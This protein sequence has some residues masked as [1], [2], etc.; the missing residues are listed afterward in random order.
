[1]I[2]SDQQ[3]TGQKR[4]NVTHQVCGAPRHLHGMVGLSVF[5]KFRDQASDF[6]TKC[7]GHA[8]ESLFPR[9]ATGADTSPCFLSRGFARLLTLLLFCLFFLFFYFLFLTLVLILLAFVSH[10]VPPFF[11]VPHLLAAMTILRREFCLLHVRNLFDDPLSFGSR[12]IIPIHPQ[13]ELGTQSRCI[14]MWYSL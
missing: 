12:K 11:V 4:H 7:G 13:K 2:A 9:K 1:M 8:F 14:E 6:V 5:L 10:C 3:D